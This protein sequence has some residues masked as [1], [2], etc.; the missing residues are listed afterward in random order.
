M[1]IQEATD[2]ILDSDDPA[3]WLRLLD[4]YISQYNQMPAAFVL[5]REYA[6]LEPLIAAMARNHPKIVQY[7]KAIRDTLPKGS[8]AADVNELYRTV[9]TRFIQQDRRQR[10]ARALER[11]AELHGPA[12]S[13]EVRV[14]YETKLYT[15]WGRRREELLRRAKGSDRLM[16]EERSEILE[17][18]WK[19]VD[20]QIE[21][22]DLPPWE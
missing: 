6:V 16:T 1:T 8:K 14:A 7:I 9:M 21:A 19:E 10:M 11:A 5:P 13:R 22:G 20:E 12:P 15:L 3:R 17:L 4:M 18:F 2:Y